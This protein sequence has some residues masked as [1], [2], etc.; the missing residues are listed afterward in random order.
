MAEF[1][2]NGRTKVGSLKKY[3]KDEY[4]LMLD[5][6]KGASNHRADD[7]ATIASVRAEK[8][9]GA[10][11]IHAQSKVGTLEKKFFSECGIKVNIKH[12]NGK[13]IDNDLTLG[14]VRKK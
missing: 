13:P 11:K 5:V 7:D 3:F 4:G 9:D 12:A 2:V 14:E 6:K 10:I 8:K 1:S